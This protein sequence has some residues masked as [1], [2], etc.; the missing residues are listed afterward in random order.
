L[1]LALAAAVLGAA[2]A[3]IPT[4]AGSETEI[5]AVNYGGGYGEYHYWSPREAPVAAGGSITFANPTSVPH[6]LL[7]HEGPATPSC[8]GTVPVNTS[9]TNWSGSCT[10]TTPGTYVF[11][12]TV[13]GAEMT[14]KITVASAGTTET[15]PAP[16][17]SPGT[18]PTQPPGSTTAAG[19]PTGSAP[20]SSGAAALGSPFTGV[21]PLGL[22]P[23]AHARTVRGSVAISQA[24]AGGRL[25]V[26]ALAARASLAAARAASGLVA[27]G[28]PFVRTDVP[29][30]VVHFVLRLNGGALRA[31]RVHG[32]LSVSVK[33]LLTP[34][35]AG[36]TT[37]STLRRLV[38]HR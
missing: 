16:G 3:V 4:A 1:L 2:V 36:A 8:G 18:T 25:E 5:K 15:T 12:C 26:E 31:L 14:A 17:P 35:G 27:I 21:H 20:A 7:L 9:G 33:A 24:G 29:A 6:G 38:L 28:R 23:S 19:A 30:G 34:P 13:H 11:Y 32:H 37:T 22:T 10:F